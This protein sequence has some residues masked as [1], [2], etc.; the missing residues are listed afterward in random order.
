[1]TSSIGREWK[2]I[3]QGL[4][5]LGFDPYCDAIRQQL[6]DGQR[7]WY[8]HDGQVRRVERTRNYQDRWQSG[9][10]TTPDS[11]K[12]ALQSTDEFEVIDKTLF[13]AV[14]SHMNLSGKNLNDGLVWGVVIH[15]RNQLRDGDVPWQ[16]SFTYVP[17][18]GESK[19]REFVN[20]L[21][22]FSGLTKD[23]DDE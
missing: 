1:M 10:A 9:H 22:G 21:H 16:K 14:R 8:Y 5:V 23:D 18:V 15:H 4:G 2:R 3:V 20:G 13:N 7:I 12:E 19:A 17:G 11:A 6:H